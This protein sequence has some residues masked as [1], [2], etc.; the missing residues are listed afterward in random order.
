MAANET[1]PTANDN[2][3]II[4]ATDQFAILL[5]LRGETPAK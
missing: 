1:A 5:E 4:H 3:V 2:F